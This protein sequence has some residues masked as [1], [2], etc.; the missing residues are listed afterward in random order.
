MDLMKVKMDTHVRRI[1]I[2][3][4]Y[5]LL[6]VL[7]SL[8]VFVANDENQAITD[9]FQLNYLLPVLIYTSGATWLSIVIFMLLKQRFSSMLSLVV[10]IVIG[11][12]IGLLMVSMFFTLISR[13]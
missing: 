13:I 11:L 7:T 5:I 6:F 3:L 9:I 10:S 4:A 8:Y 12:P 2:V 1:T